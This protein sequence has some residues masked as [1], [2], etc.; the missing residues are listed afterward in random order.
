MSRRNIVAL[1]PTENNLNFGYKGTVYVLYIELDL[2]VSL[3]QN[4]TTPADVQTLILKKFLKKI[5]SSGGIK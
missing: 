3:L 2:L 4:S 5:K 1:F